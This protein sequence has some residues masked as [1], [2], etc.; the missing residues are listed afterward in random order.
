MAALRQPTNGSDRGMTRETWV[1]PTGRAHRRPS[2]ERWRGVQK[3]R[4]ESIPTA[5][6][7]AWTWR[8]PVA[9]GRPSGE[10]GWSSEFARCERWSHGI[11]CGS[12]ST[13]DSN[14]SSTME[15]W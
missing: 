4:R 11:E 13:K 9:L 8:V 15:S 10:F 14:S 12:S 1:S 6:P 3:P 7:S 2:A 5:L